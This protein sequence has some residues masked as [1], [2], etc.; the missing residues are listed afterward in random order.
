MAATRERP[1]VSCSICKE[2]PG[3]TY[4]AEPDVG[5]G[6]PATLIR[7]VCQRLPEPVEDAPSP[8]PRTET[9][10]AS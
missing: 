8:T 7:C 3:F 6:A 5:S 1:P 9:G 10:Y 4:S 2:T